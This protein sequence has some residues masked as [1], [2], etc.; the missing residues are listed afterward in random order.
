MSA[1]RR[2]ILAAAAAAASPLAGSA[3]AAEPHPDAELIAKCD[4]YLAIRNEYNSGPEPTSQEEDDRQYF[5]LRAAEEAFL[6]TAPRTLHGLR[7]K[8]SAAQSAG[9]DEHAWQVVEDLLR[10]SGGPV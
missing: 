4:R 5:A 1:T 8:A 7:V 10:M 3:I 2:G 6:N 9:L